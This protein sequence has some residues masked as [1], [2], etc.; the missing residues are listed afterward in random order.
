MVTLQVSAAN[1][2]QVARDL[3]AA[4]TFDKPYDTLTVLDVKKAIAAK[5]PQVRRLDAQKWHLMTWHA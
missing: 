3:P 1:T 2:I 4:L 5:N